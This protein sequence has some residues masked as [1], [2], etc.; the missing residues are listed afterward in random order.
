LINQN[1]EKVS[2]GLFALNLHHIAPEIT[3]FPRLNRKGSIPS[4]IR[5]GSDAGSCVVTE[6]INQKL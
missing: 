1:S 3:K 4:A 2:Q 5:A 6:G